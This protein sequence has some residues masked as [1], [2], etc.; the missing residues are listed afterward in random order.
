MKMQPKESF[1]DIVLEHLN[2]D[3]TILPVFDR[4]I[5]QIQ[6]KIDRED[7]DLDAIETIIGRDP[8]LSAQ[9]LRSANSDFFRGLTKVST[10]H[11][12]VIRLGTGEIYDIVKRLMQADN[13]CCSNPFCRQLIQ[14]LW[15]HSMGCAIG[16]RWLA[17]QCGFDL[18]ANEAF[19]AGLLHD[20]GKLLLVKVVESL[21][22]AGKNHL[23]PS[24][25]LL[26]EVLEAFHAEHG[27]LLLTKWNLPKSYV[28]IAREHHLEDVDPNDTL[29]IVVR[30]V[31]R[32]CRKLG[33]G[34]HKDPS[35]ILAATQEANLLGLSEIFL[36]KLEIK[37]E[38]SLFVPNSGNRTSA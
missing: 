12:A 36:A 31:N 18:I 6:E 5:E 19:M 23:I 21:Q 8:S 25:L 35:I 33:I 14:N 32:A 27:A 20:M 1:I 24:K 22:R 38:D 17:R 37:L 9:V 16:S 4:S 30:L 13:T 15:Q 26:N 28:K 11:S 3:R 7:P 29:L 2:S 34:L 10:I